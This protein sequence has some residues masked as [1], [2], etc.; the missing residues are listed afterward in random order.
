MTEHS[1]NVHHYLFYTFSSAGFIYWRYS[2]NKFEK[3][4]LNVYSS[5]F[6]SLIIYCAENIYNFSILDAK[7]NIVPLTWSF[8]NLLKRLKSK[9]MIFDKLST[10]FLNYSLKPKL[11]VNGPIKFPNV[12]NYKLKLVSVKI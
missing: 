7:Y 9:T 6:I 3:Q 10:V 1:I 2:I 8:L 5:I 4:P 12:G 11:F